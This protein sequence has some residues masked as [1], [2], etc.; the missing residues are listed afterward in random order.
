VKEFRITGY[1]WNFGD[2]FNP[3][4]AVMNKTFSRKG[5]YLVQLGLLGENDSLGTSSK[6]CVRKNIRIYDKYHEWILKNED[7]SAETAERTDPAKNR[8][9]SAQI[10]IYVMN[11]LSE[12]QGEKIKEV[13]T[14]VERP[15]IEFDKYGILPASYPFLDKVSLIL[16]ENPEVRLECSIHASE[17]AIPDNSFKTAEYWAQ[18]M[19]FY[20]RNKET[21][22]R[23]F[24]C[25]GFGLL[26]PVLNPEAPES[27]GAD[28][29]VELV[30]IKR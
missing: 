14:R 17:G 5:E 27:Q 4:G 30:F 28:G 20:L 1:M 11:D 23:A 6:T 8:N 15:A 21:D 19:A 22:T 7:K 2:N 13:L 16:K 3:G 25:K 24:R 26:Q 9:L 18:E 10:R 12:S 29:I